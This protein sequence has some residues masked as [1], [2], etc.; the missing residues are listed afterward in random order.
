[1]SRKSRLPAEDI[2]ALLADVEGLLDEPQQANEEDEVESLER[3][4]D[5]LL[6]SFGADQTGADQAGQAEETPAAAG[7]QQV[8]SEAPLPE[9]Q[10]EPDAEPFAAADSEPLNLNEFPEFDEEAAFNDPEAESLDEIASPLPEDEEQAALENIVRQ[11]QQA[12]EAAGE[13]APC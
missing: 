4:V 13:S 8:V 7:D 1:M 12:A 2:D 3:S 5:E 6:E 10:E 11:L 9:W